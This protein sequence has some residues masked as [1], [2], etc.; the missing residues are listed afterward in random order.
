MIDYVLWRGDI[1]V[2]QV[3]LGEI[4]AM[5]LSYLSYM[6]FE[7]IVPGSFEEDV[8]LSD[9]AAQLLARG[10]TSSAAIDSG[11]SDTKLLEAVQRSV[12]FG[13]MRLAGYV[14]H[15]DGQEEQQFAAVTFL[16]ECGPAFIAFRG[17][18]NSVV[19]WKEDF[20]MAFSGE[21]P[22]QR[23]AVRYAEAA[24]HH[25]G[26]RFILGGHSK[27][28]NLAVYA[29]VF[30]DTSAKRQVDRVYNFDGPGFNEETFASPAFSRLTM[31]VYTFV[32]Q[33]SVIGILLWH[34][35]PFTIIQSDGVGPLQHNPYT[36]QLMGGAF[37]RVSER[38]SSSYL[39]DETLKKW[40]SGLS[41]Q[42]RRQVIDGI[43]SVLS[44][45]D[46]KNI[47]DLLEPRNALAVIR[48]AGN[49]DEETRGVIME[50]LR[51]LGAALVQAMPGFVDRT[52]T[53]IIGKV[54]RERMEWQEEEK[55]PQALAA[56]TVEGGEET[57]EDKTA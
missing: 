8:R 19:G 40:I 23:D 27:G 11:E 45:S 28:G 22:S 36:W 4:D 44:A 56:Q 15:V 42:T 14:N 1:P 20:N 46:G 3:A 12:R 31:P 18:D 26:G 32:P 48:A 13:S 17:T 41:A 21:V 37:T 7:D 38:T 54:R 47:A 2:C 52:A 25:I 29:G 5:I 39:A 53:E 30:A 9:A 24:V 50:A 57:S 49:M 51:L 35:E 43:F 55:A 33:T 10:I 34:A 6:P 16:P